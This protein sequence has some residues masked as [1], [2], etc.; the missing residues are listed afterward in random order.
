MALSSAR[1]QKFLS[2]IENTDDFNQVVVAMKHHYKQLQFKARSK[3]SI[4]DQVSWTGRK[5]YKEGKVVE[6][7]K[8]RL[9]VEIAGG[10]HWRVPASML[11]LKKK[12]K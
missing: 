6:F 7:G 10:L 1:I 8:R 9:V 3:F 11:T 5:G 2:G 12:G 4:G